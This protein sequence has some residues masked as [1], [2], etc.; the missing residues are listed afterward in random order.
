[1]SGCVSWNDCFQLIFFFFLPTVMAYLNNERRRGIRKKPSVYFPIV[2]AV[3]G[4]CQS[5][6]AGQCFALIKPGCRARWGRL[7][8]QP[9]FGGDK[10][11]H[12]GIR[13][14]AAASWY[15]STS[16]RDLPPPRPLKRC[17]A[18]SSGQLLSEAIYSTSRNFLVISLGGVA[19]FFTS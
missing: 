13:D 17:A 9:T 6:Q 8:L 14:Q 1:M 11:S 7:G 4:S 18:R 15:G 5:S 19:L 16:S 3:L 10:A 12:R 2:T